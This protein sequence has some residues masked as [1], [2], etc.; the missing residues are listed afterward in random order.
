MAMQTSS[1]QRR[2]AGPVAPSTGKAIVPLLKMEYRSP[3]HRLPIP[4]RVLARTDRS[5]V[6]ATPFQNKTASRLS[7]N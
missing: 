6:A 7:M 4:N 1:K 3:S 5:R 2:A